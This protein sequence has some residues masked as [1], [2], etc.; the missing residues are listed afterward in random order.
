FFTFF[1]TFLYIKNLG[2]VKGTD[3]SLYIFILYMVIT[4]AWSGATS[5]GLTKPIML[6]LFTLFFVIA[7]K[8]IVLNFKQIAYFFLISNVIF[9]ILFYITF[10]NPLDV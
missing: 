7:Q 2:K 8:Y 1:L 3:S 6:I 4:V 10:G 5:Y 9:I